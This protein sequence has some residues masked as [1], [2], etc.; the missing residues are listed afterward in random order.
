MTF[1]FAIENQ[2]RVGL[3]PFVGCGGMEWMCSEC[4]MG[5][6]NGRSGMKRVLTGSCINA[7]KEE[8]I[9]LKE[10]GRGYCVEGRWCNQWGLE[11]YV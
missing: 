8:N 5:S 6:R 11:E 4:V 9:C 2:K 3:Q 1:E 7:G 10:G